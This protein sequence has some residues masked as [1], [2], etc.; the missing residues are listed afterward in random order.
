MKNVI[1]EFEFAE[2]MFRFKNINTVGTYL[3]QLFDKFCYFFNWTPVQDFL[4]PLDYARGSLAPM[5]PPLV[6]RP[7][8]R[9]YVINGRKGG[10]K[11]TMK[12]DH[13][14]NEK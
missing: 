5:P 8:R 10:G 2:R 3:F 4:P 7:D 14:R 1:V 12:H 6:A 11:F 9:R 13:K